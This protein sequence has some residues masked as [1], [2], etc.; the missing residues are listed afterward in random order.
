[1]VK[2]KKIINP[3]RVLDPHLSWQRGY[4]QVIKKEELRAYIIKYG[5]KIKTYSEKPTIFNFWKIEEKYRPLIIKPIQ[6]TGLLEIS[7][8][9]VGESKKCKEEELNRI[10]GVSEED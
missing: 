9:W 2:N 3:D 8:Y 5:T 4:R 1:M 10:I 7:V 6:Y